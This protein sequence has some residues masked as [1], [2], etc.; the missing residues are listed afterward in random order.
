M[1]RPVPGGGATRAACFAVSFIR[2]GCPRSG[3][4]IFPISAG[5]PDGSGAPRRRRAPLFR[6]DADRRKGYFSPSAVRR[7]L[8][9][10]PFGKGCQPFQDLLLSGGEGWL[11]DGRCLRPAGASGRSSRRSRR[12]GAHPGPFPG[13]G[14]SS[15]RS[16]RKRQGPAGRRGVRDRAGREFP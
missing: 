15:G 3:R 9:G 8:K 14:C 5:R 16:I 12:E 1:R 11:P 6:E 10:E 4:S 13:G 2:R 7:R